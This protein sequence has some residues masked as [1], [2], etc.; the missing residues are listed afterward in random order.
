MSDFISTFHIDASLLIAQ[1]I[2]FAI[3]CVALYYLV[4][5]PLSALMKD[6][7]ET[8]EIGLKKATESESLLVEAKNQADEIVKQA[9][10]ESNVILGKAQ[11]QASTVITTA[12]KQALEKKEA[13]LRQAEIEAQAEKVEMEKAFQKEAAD[14]VIRGMKR[15]LKEDVTD[16]VKQKAVQKLSL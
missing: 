15:V 8:I 7:Q 1:L 11:D 14:V 12:E 5:K 4:V 9:R 3:V 13:I 2:N 6:R 10:V 16:E